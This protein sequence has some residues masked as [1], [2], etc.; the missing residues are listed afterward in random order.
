MCNPNQH[1]DARVSAASSIATPGLRSPSL[2]LSDLLFR[3]PYMPHY[4]PLPI[5]P[6]ESKQSIA[7]HA[8]SAKDPYPASGA[9]SSR[10]AAIWSTSDDEILLQ[11][12]SSGLNWQP[13]ASRHFP[14]KTA[15]ACRKRHERLV[16]RRHIED[17]DTHK[18]ELLAQ[19]YMA[20]RQEMWEILAS[21]VG[22]RWG[23]IEAKVSR[24]RRCYA[25]QVLTK[26]QSAWKRASRLCSQ[27]LAR[28]KGNP[29]PTV[30]QRRI[31]VIQTTTVILALAL[32]RK[33]RWKP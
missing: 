2:L 29:M 4:R 6:K 3:S 20:C 22:E 19:E 17:W 15:N 30:S 31:E 7:S 8:T 25:K 10:N 14:N 1:L 21:R 32:D 12:R 16:E 26:S 27:S 13:I 28:R 18:L 11:A 24:A 9:A 23:V 5:M 33:L